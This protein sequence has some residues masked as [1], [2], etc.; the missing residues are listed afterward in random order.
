MLE[1]NAQVKIGDGNNIRQH[2]RQFLSLKV[3]KKPLLIA[4]AQCQLLLSVCL[5]F[6]I[7]VITPFPAR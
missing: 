3:Q 4:Q 5:L 6:F 2:W 7:Q 1:P